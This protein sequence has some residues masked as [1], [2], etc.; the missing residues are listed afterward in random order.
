[1]FSPMRACGVKMEFKQLVLSNRDGPIIISS[2]RN[3]VDKVAHAQYS[4]KPRLPPIY[5][6]TSKTLW[7]MESNHIEVQ[8]G[9]YLLH[10]DIPRLENSNADDLFI[11][12]GL[13]WRMTAMNPHLIT[14]SNQYNLDAEERVLFKTFV[15]VDPFSSDLLGLP[16]F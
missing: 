13:G 2:G 4:E 12:K 14:V 1:M 10:N 7:F 3:L 6:K 15:R 8:S 9:L 16:N 5:D 11:S